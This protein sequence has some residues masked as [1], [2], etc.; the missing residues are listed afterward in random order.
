MKE[1]VIKKLKCSIFL[2]KRKPIGIVQIIHG[3]C[4]HKE[5]YYDFMKFLSN[6]GYIA[7]IH[8]Q[9]GHG[10]SC[11]E[12]GYFG[13]DFNVLEKD[14]YEVTKYLK[15]EYKGLK[16]TLLGHSMG[17]LVARK[18]IQKHDNDI[19]KL[20][21]SGAP[22]YNP[23]SNV[24]LLMAGIIGIIKT[25]KY[26]SSFLNNITF[27]NYN[28]G[29]DLKNSWLSSNK[30]VVEEYNNDEY[31]GYIFTIN[32]FKLLY[33]LMKDCFKKSK[34]ELKNKNLNILLLAGKDD[35]VITSEKKFNA[36]YSFI[37]NIGYYNVK[38]KLYDGMR[39]EI[40]NEMNN[41]LVYDDILTFLKTK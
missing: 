16:I 10:L 27:M 33:N 11:K 34:Y 14:A 8:D 22:T 23:L 37:K 25:D 18:Y 13:S 30:K 38:K 3:M 35:P 1:V 40:L 32:G 7:V 19:E 36:L 39:H 6:N 2:P 24:G 31:C 20:I 29:Y 28:K 5:R 41:K 9:K 21:L 26:R 4:E 17:S 12:L 15:K